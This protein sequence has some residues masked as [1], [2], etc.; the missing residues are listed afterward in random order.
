MPAALVVG[1]VEYRMGRAGNPRG[2][3]GFVS[4]VATDPDARRWGS[5]RVERSRESG[6]GYARAGVDAL[7]AWFRAR[8]V[9]Q[10]HLTASADAAPSTPPWAS[11]PSRT[12]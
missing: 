2:I 6:G 11:G 7:P 4:S 9:V 8:G 10:V 1:T 3:I 12:P 5:P